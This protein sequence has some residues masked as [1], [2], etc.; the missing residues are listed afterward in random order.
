VWVGFDEL[1]TL[2]KGETGAKAG[3]PIWIDFMRAALA[4]EPKLP[5]AAPPEVRWRRIDRETGLLAAPDQTKKT[6]FEC[7]LAGQ[8][9]TEFA[10]RAASGG[11]AQTGARGGDTEAAVSRIVPAL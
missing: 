9:P 5:F 8:E 1:R 11:L 4:G 10:P 3:A 2:G 7:F 6:R